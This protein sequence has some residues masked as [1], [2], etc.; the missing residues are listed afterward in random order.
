MQRAGRALLRPARIVG[1]ALLALGLALQIAA[2][3]AGMPWRHAWWDV[4]HRLAPRDRPYPGADPAVDPA[5]E[6]AA[7]LAADLAVGAPGPA[8]L[9]GIDDESTRALGPW[10][11]PRDVL[12]RLVG[13][14]DELGASALA[15]ALDVD[16]PDPLS[17]PRLAARYRSLGMPEAADGMADLPDTDV[18]LLRSLEALPAVLPIAG[19][20]DVRP[21]AGGRGCAFPAPPVRLDVP[22][23]TLEA[24]YDAA[25]PPIAG[26]LAGR[27]DLRG[28]SLGAVGLRAARGLVL[29]E[30]EAVQRIC[31]APVLMLGIEALRM[32]RG[33]APA[34]VRPTASGL[35]VFL[36]DP[37]DPATLR[38]PL[39]RDGSLWLHFAAP[40]GT[41]PGT[42][43]ETAA[44]AA[45]P[46]MRYVPAAALFRPGFD[47]GRIAGRIVLVDVI[48]QGRADEHRSPLGTLVWGA[49]AHIQAIEQIVAGDF[50]RRPWFMSGL[51]TALMLVGCVLV[52]ALVPAARPEVAVGVIA[53]A[54][55]AVMAAGSAAFLAGLLVDAAAPAVGITVVAAATLTA[56]LVERNRA[57]LVSE[58]ALV[59]ER[60]GRAVLQGELDAAAE[61]QRVLLP[62]RRF[63]L[64]GRLDLAA[65]VAPARQ[66]GGDFYDHFMLDD[67]HLFFLVADV[68]GKGAEASQFMLLSKTLWKSVALRAGRDS[69]PDLGAIMATANVEILRDNPAM[70]FVTGLAG[71]LDV[72]TGAL[73][74]ASAGHDAPFL[75][76]NARAPARLQIEAGPPLGLAEGHLYPV[77]RSRLA[78]GDRLCI[79][80]D[81]ITEAMD[82]A[83]ERFGP[84]R[85]R[86]ALAEMPPQAGSTGTVTR[87]LARVSAFTG[88]AEQSDDLTLM[89]VSIPG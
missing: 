23:A 36:G 86:A 38:F 76:G 10:P 24:R 17:P 56:T 46:E 40:P 30:V 49:E 16:A 45:A 8:V 4:L 3:D 82:A 11:W 31:D 33:G 69:A 25:I 14:L 79:F 71:V 42:P 75:F 85:L 89:V 55:A 44:D 77:S 47:P 39:E 83:G 67:R 15:L 80:S 6:L 21:G 60:L 19:I 52:I 72:E 48:A 9:V 61:M 84:D 18:L 27:P 57:R 62:A 66:V 20:P 74:C 63:V 2:G 29:R 78:P 58:L 28:V 7:D 26:L 12:A 54:V 41:P 81:G 13:R 32:A 70:M 35:A 1:I 68:S 51:E 87:L 53:A 50:L 73:A 5:A 64:S 43:P 88:A 37:D 22:P 34:V 59:S 65:H